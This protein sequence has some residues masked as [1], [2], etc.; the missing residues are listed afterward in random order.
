MMELNEQTILVMNPQCRW[1]S[2]DEHKS[3]I[4]INDHNGCIKRRFFVDNNVVK[5]INGIDGNKSIEG[6]TSHINERYFWNLS[7]NNVIE[8]VKSNLTG[9]SLFLGEGETEPTRNLNFSDQYIKLKFRIFSAAFSQRVARIFSGLFL[10][11]VF[12]S[13]LLITFCFNFI[14]FISKIGVSQFPQ[15]SSHGIIFPF[16]HFDII[17][18]CLIL[19]YISLIFHEFG[20][21]SASEKFNAKCGEIG[22]GFYLLTPVLYSDVTEVWRLKKSQRVIVDLAGVYMQFLFMSIL[23][24]IYITTNNQIYLA[25]SLFIGVGALVN[26]NPFLRFDGYWVLSDITNTVNLR[27]RSNLL[28]NQFYGWVIGINKTWRPTSLMNVFLTLYGVASMF[29][30]I[31]FILYMVIINSDSVINFPLKI[32]EIIKMWSRGDTVPVEFLATN[33]S[34]FLLTLIFYF[35]AIKLIYNIFK[36]KKNAI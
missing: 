6:L 29:F 18:P 20:H 28:A 25:A 14:L 3:L 19:N 26:L 7:T 16:L 24:L 36:Q 13:L 15:F 8:I 21:S 31:A 22:F 1:F 33:F 27:S 12:Y 4:F 32:Y 35:L 9:K 30:I 34:S 10:P 17:I 11:K 2:F 23:S 5:I